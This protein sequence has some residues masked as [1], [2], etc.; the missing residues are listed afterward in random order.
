MRWD[1]FKKGRIV[2]ACTE[3]EVPEFREKAK[4]EL[5]NIRIE[6]YSIENLHCNGPIRVYYH[7]DKDI[8]WLKPLLVSGIPRVKVNN[9]KVVYWEDVR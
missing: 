4:R 7:Y 5:G 8:N 1:L 9:H 3:E 6:K 2:V